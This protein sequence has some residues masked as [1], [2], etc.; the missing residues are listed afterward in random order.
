MDVSA[1]VDREPGERLVEQKEFLV[2]R[3]RHRNLN[4]AT[5]AIRRLPQRSIGDISQTDALKCCLRM[6]DEM[7]LALEVDQRV[8]ARRRQAQQRLRHVVNDGVAPEQRDDLIG[9]R[10]SEVGTAA[11]RDTGDVL[12]EEFYRAGIGCQLAG[13][14]VEQC[15]LAGAVRSDDQPALARLDVQVD[16]GGDVQAAESLGEI[17]DG[18]GAHG[19]ASAPPGSVLARRS[20]LRQAMRQRRTLPGTS[21][22]GIRIKMATK[23]APSRTIPRSI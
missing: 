10:H 9:A 1:F 16:V 22:S 7:S 5:L 19:L 6:L 23:I 4:A 3:Q 13:D 17:P 14:Q 15:R 8:P 18:E 11:A 20:R 12:P 21:P 2:L